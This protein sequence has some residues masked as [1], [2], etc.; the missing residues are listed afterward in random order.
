MVARWRALGIGWR[1]R[2]WWVADG[3]WA[4]LVSRDGVMDD[5]DGGVRRDGG[6]SW[7]TW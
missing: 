2:W 1:D 5:V 6:G 3:G 4:V 7:V